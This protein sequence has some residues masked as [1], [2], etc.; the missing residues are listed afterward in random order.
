MPNTLSANLPDTTAEKPIAWTIAG[1]DSGGGAGIQADLL[2]FADFQVHGCS[3]ITAST[4]QNSQSLEHLQTLPLEHLSAQLQCLQDDMPARAIKIGMLANASIT[5]KIAAFLKNTDAFVVCDPVLRASSGDELLEYSA[6]STL[7]TQLLPCID[8]LTPNRPEAEQLL[9]QTLSSNADIEK[10]AKQLLSYGCKAVLITG[11]HNE[12]FT[13]QTTQNQSADFFTNGKESYWLLADKIASPHTH[14]SGCTLSSA[15]TACVAQGYALEDAL[16]LAKAYVT[17][18]IRAARP[19]GKGPGAVAH[20][21]WPRA[22]ADLPRIFKKL[23]APTNTNETKT[24]ARF[25]DCG[26]KRLGLYPVVD[27]IEW[28]EK[29]L[30]LG[31]ETIQLRIKDQPLANL[32][33]QISKAVALAKHHDCRLFINDYWQLAIKYGAYGVHLGQEDL[34][35]ADLGKIAA[36]GLRLGL[37]THSY[38]EIARAH[39]IGPSYIAIGPIYETTTKQMR[40]AQQG[41]KR[42]SEWVDLLSGSY[43]LV[44]IGGINYERAI[45]VLSSGV[46]SVAMV[47][48]ITQAEDYIAEVDRLL[49]LLDGKQYLINNGEY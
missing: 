29:L 39:A 9:Q 34:D 33:A 30:P 3:V 47:S 49:A 12:G 25:V 11:G 13:E 37:S 26:S 36:A 1:S 4:A 44:A 48:A 28:L 27:N 7:L 46:G 20:Q 40:F 43:P 6:R 42:L 2:S 16:I 35:Q 41:V 22:L 23:P 14:G 8:L 45:K 21:G 17:Q 15:I 38:W 5:E 19:V 10:A 32:E 18:G 31:I 24:P